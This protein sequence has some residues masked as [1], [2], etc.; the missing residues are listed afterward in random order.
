M[1]FFSVLDD[2]DNDEPKVAKP[3]APKNTAA[4]A[5]TAG[6]GTS[7]EKKAPASAAPT[8]K[9]D[10]KAKSG[11]AKPA[12]AEAPEVI[13]DDKGKE[14]ARGG[15]GHRQGKSGDKRHDSRYA[16]EGEGSKKE[17]KREKDRRSSDPN[18]PRGQKKQG[19]TSFGTGNVK[20]EAAEGEKNTQA[21]LDADADVEET[22]EVEAAAA[23]PAEPEVPTLSLADFLAQRNA[24]RANADLFGSKTV[25]RKVDQDDF[26]GLKKVVDDLEEDPFLGKKKKSGQARSATD[27]KPA[28]ELSFKVQDEVQ[29][30]PREEKRRDRGGNSRSSSGRSGGS[31][32]GKSG[33]PRGLNRALNGIDLNDS[34]AFPTIGAKA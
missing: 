27:S 14:N 4:A 20:N 23:E 1:N 18:K 30:S 7:K 10:D 17:G 13:G 22:E 29:E 26:S 3:A 24:Q 16:K 8:A 25:A 15:A 19:G 11:N 28:I 2:S 6:G 33:S 9:K 21:I 12:K 34:S 31:G 5:S 32:K